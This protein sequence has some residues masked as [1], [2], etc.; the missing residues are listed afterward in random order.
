MERKAR[1]GP[2]KDVT[3]YIA[4]APARAR[5]H[6]RKLRKDI[7]KAAPEAVESISYRVPVYKLEGMLVGFAAFREHYSF[8]VMSPAAMAAFGDELKGYEVSKATIRVPLER[9]LP[10]SLVNRIVRARVRENEMRAR[11]REE[12]KRSRSKARTRR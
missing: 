4:S 6:L 2:A 10:S 9:P 5:A 7:K 1:P 3:E 8:F 11:E 12:R